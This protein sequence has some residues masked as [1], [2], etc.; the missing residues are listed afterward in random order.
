MIGRIR[1]FFAR[2]KTQ[3]SPAKSPLRRA[4]GGRKRARRDPLKEEW[5]RHW[6]PDD[7]EDKEENHGK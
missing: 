6:L 3:L 4:Y 2:R 5:I 7:H 1:A